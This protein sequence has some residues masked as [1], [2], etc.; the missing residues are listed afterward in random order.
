MKTRSLALAGILSAFAI[1]SLAPRGQAQD[2]ASADRGWVSLFD[3]ESLANWNPIGTANWRLENGAMVADSGNG[4]LVSTD[5]YGDFELRAEFW[6]DPEANSGIFIRCTDPKEV[7]GKNAYEVNIWDTRPDPSYGTGAIVHVAKV[8][9]MPKAG[10]KWNVYEI[11]AKG[12]KFTVKLNG[13][14][15]VD[16]AEDSKFA[17][18]HIALQH[19][20]G[21]GDSDKGAVKFRKVEI[22]TP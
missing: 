1:F 10:G 7:T 9:P 3:G 5:E 17:R 21:A 2:P 16:G 12:P 14:T 11:T 20:L 22:R 18:G 6:I 13:Q 15:T 4:F 8:D 19:G